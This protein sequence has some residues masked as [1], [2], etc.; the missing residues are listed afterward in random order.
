M[1]EEEWNRVV[2]TN[3]TGCWLVAKYVCIRMR[4]A[5]QGGSVIN[6]SSTGGLNRGHLPGGVAYAS[7]KAGLNAMTKVISLSFA[8]FSVVLYWLMM[9]SFACFLI[10]FKPRL[11]L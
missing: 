3:L 2:K 4:D 10:V 8:N 1:S 7:S 9:I 5:K 6:I 11:S